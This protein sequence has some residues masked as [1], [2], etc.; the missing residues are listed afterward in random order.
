MDSVIVSYTDRF[1]YI[2]DL[3]N[4]LLFILSQ[5]KREQGG[6]GPLYQS[7]PEEIDEL[8]K[9]IM[10]DLQENCLNVGKK[11]GGGPQS[12]SLSTGFDRRYINVD[13][14]SETQI[15]QL[16]QFAENMLFGDDGFTIPQKTLF[17]HM[18]AAMWTLAKLD[19]NTYAKEINSQPGGLCKIDALMKIYVMGQNNQPRVHPLL[20]T[21]CF[22]AVFPHVQEKYQQ[23]GVLDLFQ[24]EPVCDLFA[25]PCYCW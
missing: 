13:E 6:E 3:Q 23:Y 2:K 14:L 25:S 20:K 4:K 5:G 17:H 8:Y 21:M 15:E 12:I 16:Q 19:W 18:R 22:D 10:F 1:P 11:K 24:S 7:S 9:Q